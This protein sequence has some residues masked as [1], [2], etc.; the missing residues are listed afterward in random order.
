MVAQLIPAA[1]ENP[2]SVEALAA[3][4]PIATILR[5]A[6]YDCHSNETRWPWYSRVAP[7]SWIIARHV[8]AGR[9]QVN[10]S[11]WGTYY[12]RT[13]R[14]KLQWIGR[15]VRNSKMPPWSYRLTHPEARL[16]DDDRVA[17]KQWVESALAASA[18]QKAN[19]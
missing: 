5:R 2:P 17:L 15:A 7:L 6:C 19:K 4:P 11:E 3:P 10:F 12:P 14:R 8:T 1:R 18:V 16:S 9:R 13:R